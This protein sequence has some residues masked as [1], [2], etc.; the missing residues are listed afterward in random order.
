MQK[1]RGIALMFVMVAIL[2]IG[3]MSVAYF[4][5]RDNSVAISSNIESAARARAVAESGLE[6]AVAILET[7]INWQTEHIDGLLVSDL[8]VGDGIITIAILDHET[9]LP[10]TEETSEVEITITSTVNQ[11]SQSTQAIATVIPNEEEYDVD[12]SEYAAFATSTIEIDD[13][14][15]IQT[16]QASPLSLQ[17]N[18]LRIAT[19]ATNPLSVEIES[20][21]QRST[22]ELHTRNNASSMVAS[23]NV[24]RQTFT[25]DPVL[26]DPPTAPIEGT[27]FTLSSNSESSFFGRSSVS[28]WIRNFAFGN[29]QS[30]E[31][32]RNMIVQQGVYNT[33]SVHLGFGTTI[34][35]QGDVTLTV[36][37]DLSLSGASILL[38]ESATLT[39]HVGGDV[40][41]HSSYIGNE[42]R[43]IQSWMDTTR[44]QLYGHGSNDWEVGGISTLKAE[45]YAPQSDVSIEGVTT[46]CGRIAAEEISMQDASRLLYDTSLDHGGYADHSSPLYNE[47]GE[48]H[49]ELATITQLDAGLIDSVID[50]I[51]ATPYETASSHW[52]DW[53]DQPT[54]RPNEVIFMLMMYGADTSRWELFAQQ[55][56]GTYQN[57]LAGGI[58]Q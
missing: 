42:Q 39:I 43:S 41:I 5:S 35:I 48:V 8:Q 29:S 16:W 10:P 24:D 49:P 40:D 32:N 53:K 28:D 6:V 14:A 19:L 27:P 13:V 56:R 2:V 47:N 51:R 18:P 38:G 45:L 31:G 46:L 52:R 7:N 57:Q 21:F 22:L 44:V 50:S 36:E 26:P 37:H 11:V 34:E 15:S 20:P 55:V 23:S 33:D 54:E 1:R 9:H 4:G 25:S 12:Y 58:R 30:S 3:T 17:N